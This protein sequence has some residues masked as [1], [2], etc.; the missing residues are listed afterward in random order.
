MSFWNEILYKTIIKIIDFNKIYKKKNIKKN[1]NESLNSKIKSRILLNESNLIVYEISR[2][3][4]NNQISIFSTILHLK[5]LD[6]SNFRIHLC[7]RATKLFNTKFE[8]FAFKTNYATMSID[9]FQKWKKSMYWYVSFL[10]TSSNKSIF[11]DFMT[12]FFI[13]N[14]K[15]FLIY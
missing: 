12:S 1:I 10:K 15:T 4:R 2:S 7:S 5:T 14:F 11:D 6:H 3:N 8:N 9:K 13:K